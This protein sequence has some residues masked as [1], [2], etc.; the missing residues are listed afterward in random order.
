MKNLEK[1]HSSQI[2][3]W[4][5]IKKKNCRRKIYENYVKFIELNSK[6]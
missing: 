1:L 5:T 2:P 3:E 4:E 6:I